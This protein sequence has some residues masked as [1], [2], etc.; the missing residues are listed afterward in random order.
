MN[1]IC[2]KCKQYHKLR[3]YHIWLAPWYHGAGPKAYICID[4]IVKLDRD[5]AHFK[6][7]LTTHECEARFKKF[8]DE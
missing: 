2:P 5:E 7:V 3:E 4:C 8:M 1:G 6:Y